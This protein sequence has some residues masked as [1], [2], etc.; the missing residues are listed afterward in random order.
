MR[1]PLEKEQFNTTLQHPLKV[2]HLFTPHQRAVQS[3][4]ITKILKTLKSFCLR[5]QLVPSLY[6]RVVPGSIAVGITTFGWTPYHD[7]R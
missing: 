2:F 3:T 1:V 7:A 4:S 6:V 5:E